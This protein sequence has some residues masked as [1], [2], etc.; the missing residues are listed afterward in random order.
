MGAGGKAAGH[1]AD[2]SPPMGGEVRNTW[3]CT[4]SECG[5]RKMPPYITTIRMWFLHE[6]CKNVVRHR[7]GDTNY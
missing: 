2:N 4:A 5:E 6:Y 1:V 7:G 3:S